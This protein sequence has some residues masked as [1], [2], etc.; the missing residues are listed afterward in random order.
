MELAKRLD[1]L[2]EENEEVPGDDDNDE[3]GDEVED[4]EE[5]GA[6]G[7]VPEKSAVLA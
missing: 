3:D 6:D 7:V 5:A 4:E 1:K 2:R